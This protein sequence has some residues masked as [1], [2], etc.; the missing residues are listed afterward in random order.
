[1]YREILGIDVKDDKTF[2][3]HWDRLRHHFEAID[4]LVLLP[5]ALERAAFAEP[6][7]YK[8][9][10]LY[11][12]DP[13]N[14]GLYNGPY[15]VSELASGSH[16]TL[17][18]NPYWAG[19]AP[20]FKRITIRAIENTAA[21][22]ANLLS[23]TIDMAAGE[24]G[25]PLDEALAFDKRRGDRFNVIYKPGLTFEHVDCNLDNPILADIRVRR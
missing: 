7:Q 23:G 25:L 21:L 20:Y 4:D 15:R 17:V 9:R 12:T 18:P 3:M 10:T 16:I 1:M 11:A 24:I 6:A 2:T 5:G 22:E 13:T 8:V 14:P 19:P